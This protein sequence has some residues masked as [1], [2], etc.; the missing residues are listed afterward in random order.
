MTMTVDLRGKRRSAN[1]VNR[2]PSPDNGHLGESLDNFL[3]GRVD[4][5]PN[6]ADAAKAPR[7]SFKQGIGEGGGGLTLRPSEK[8]MVHGVVKTAEKEKRE[9]FQEAQ[10]Q[11]R[12]AQER[13]EQE[14]SKKAQLQR[15]AKLKQ[16][17][18][19]LDGGSWHGP[20]PAMPK[21]T[22]TRRHRSRSRDRRGSRQQQ[23][24]RS[25]SGCSGRKLSNSSAESSPNNDKEEP[26]MDQLNLSQRL[27]G[28]SFMDDTTDEGDK[29]SDDAKES[30][31][32]KEN[33][34]VQKKQSDAT[35]RSSSTS[36]QRR[37]SSRDRSQ[38]RSRALSSSRHGSSHGSD[39]RSS[40]RDAR[41]SGRRSDSRNQRNRSKSRT[42]GSEERDRS[43]SSSRDKSTQSSSHDGSSGTR[44]YAGRRGRSQDRQKS[45]N[46][47]TTNTDTQQV[48]P[49][50]RMRKGDAASLRAAK[51]SQ[52][53][54]NTGT[55]TVASE[56][57]GP[58]AHKSVGK[59][60]PTRSG[61]VRSSSR[62]K[63]R[64]RSS[65]RR[66]SSRDKAP[67]KA[68]STGMSDLKRAEN[69]LLSFIQSE[70]I[71][72][73][74]TQPKRSASLGTKSDHMAASN[75]SPS[76]PDDGRSSGHHRRKGIRP[77]NN[78]RALSPKLKPDD[79]RAAFRANMTDKEFKPTSILDFNEI[80]DWGDAVS[81]TKN[82]RAVKHSS[83]A[84][85]S[86]TISEDDDH[87][88]K[89]HFTDDFPLPTNRIKAPAN[90][91]RRTTGMTS[92]SLSVSCHT[93]SRFGSNGCADKPIVVS[94]KAP[95]NKPISYK[96]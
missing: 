89:E 36:R 83:K 79:F 20:P 71:S 58:H 65:Q 56:P 21:T 87:N 26:T 78:N 84:G 63:S 49:K 75:S 27:Y 96:I 12:Q 37:S 44:K 64:A 90:N 15:R 82:R 70:H 91:V 17:G 34:K 66:S 76:S 9:Q 93:T 51:T 23:R 31:S 92:T 43:R 54:A 8:D 41:R 18:G 55:A 32:S 13:A 57:A 73:P 67:R 42:K 77:N 11:Q 61:H 1:K 80:D 88:G 19:G 68:K 3:Q 52:A 74:L 38:D 6:A 10:R 72:V 5:D 59:D 28:R 60:L 81:K 7:P 25:Q 85:V 94:P 35:K 45:Q 33:E 53:T 14:Q 30:D 69:E 50:R 22:N 2:S 86:T 46:G 16:K 40:S 95:T 39:G 29:D 48:S 47:E 24:S 4:A 62:D